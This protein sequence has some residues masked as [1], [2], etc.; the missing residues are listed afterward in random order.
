MKNIITLFIS[1]LFL[2]SCGNSKTENENDSNKN[3]I[4]VKTIIGKTESEIEKILGK[5]E[6]SEK[7]S[8]SNT[9]CKDIP[10]EKKFYQKNKFE[11]VFIDG[12][13][14]WITINN[15]S[16]F[17]FNSENITLLGLSSTVPSFEN[18]I[19]IKWNDIENIN[20]V[21]FFNNGENKIEYIYIKG[22]T[23]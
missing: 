7:I 18:T 23:K 11:I 16:N 15:I 14:D 10:C 19:S 1:A 6:N 3:I 21:T 4:D 13:S 12:K 9:P 17:D 8:P 2:V 20:D 5:A 22:Y